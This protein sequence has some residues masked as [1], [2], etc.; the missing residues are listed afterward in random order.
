MNRSS[1]VSHLILVSALVCVPRL[2][3]AAPSDD[4]AL[5]EE[6]FRQAKQAMDEQRWEDACPK[7]TES[8]RLDPGG[9]TML[10]LALCHESQGKTAAAW[11]E[12]GEAL[13]FAKR[14]SRPNREAIAREHMDALKPRLVRLRLTVDVATGRLKDVV[15]KRDGIELKS[16]SWD[17]AAPVDPGEHVIEASAPGYAPF[18]VT[19]KVAGEG[20]VIDVRVPPLEPVKA[21]SALAVVV[22][23]DGAPRTPPGPEREAGGSRALRIGSYAAGGIGLALLG[24]GTYFSFAASSDQDDANRLCPA[25]RCSNRDGVDASHDAAQKADFATGF[26]IGGA[27]ALGA[28]AAMWLLSR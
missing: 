6:L 23:G 9:G 13:S 7:L 26:F 11:A 5:A 16:A 28:A 24:A 15:I 3:A 14:D 4:I 2:A 19:A 25:P 21:S 12:F 8:Y 1:L 20:Q 17:V 10:T 22:P 18:L 27:V